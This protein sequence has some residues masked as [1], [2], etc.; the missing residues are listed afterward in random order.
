M[1]EPIL[2][3]R[4]LLTPYTAAEKAGFARTQWFST[5]GSGYMA[6][7]STQPQTVGYSLADSPVGL[8]AWIYEKLVNWTDAYPWDDDEGGCPDIYFL[9][10][11]IWQ[12]VL[13]SPHMDLHLPILEIRSYG[14][15]TCIL[16]GLEFIRR[17]CNGRKTCS[18]TWRV[19]FPPGTHVC[20]S[21][22]SISEILEQNPYLLTLQLD[23]HYR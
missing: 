17:R 15:D 3:L 9:L 21:P 19:F 20:S 5:Q 1:Y 23:S 13:F 6:E 7:H 2:Y 12:Y 4:H 14:V 16:R 22:V 11:L 18:S 10:T 8:L